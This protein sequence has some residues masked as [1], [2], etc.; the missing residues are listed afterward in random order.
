MEG[1]KGGRCIVKL[2]SGQAMVRSRADL[3]SERGERSRKMARAENLPKRQTTLTKTTRVKSLL[4]PGPCG[5]GSE[6]LCKKKGGKMEGGA[7]LYV[8]HRRLGNSR[9]WRRKAHRGKAS[10]RVRGAFSSL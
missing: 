3:T 7:L 9:T 8:L 4:F 2:V 6:R 10:K 5:K 1:K